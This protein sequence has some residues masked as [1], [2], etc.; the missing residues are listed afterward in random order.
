MG[1]SGQPLDHGAQQDIPGVAIGKPGAGNETGPQARLG[2]A[3][4]NRRIVRQAAGVAEKVAH[5]DRFGRQRRLGK[6]TGH[7]RVKVDRAFVDQR[8][9]RQGQE[10]LADRA[11]LK[12]MVGPD[13]LGLES[14]P[15]TVRTAMKPSASVTLRLM[16]GRPSS[17]I[18]RRA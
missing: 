7:G 3:R 2:H 12:Q 6:V 18:S 1:E 16:P 14:A 5:G 13:G 8:Q 4:K 15:P 11:D 10:R 9:D 17:A